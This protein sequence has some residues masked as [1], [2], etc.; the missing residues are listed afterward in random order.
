MRESLAERE[1]LL[2]IAPHIISPMRFVLVHVDGLRPRWVIRIG[3]A[4]YDRLARRDILPPTNTLDLRDD[5]AGKPLKEQFGKAFEY[6]DCWVD[7]SRLVTL[8]ALDAKEHGATIL[9]KTKLAAANQADGCWELSLD[10]DHARTAEAT[11]LVNA[12]GPWAGKLRADILDHAPDPS[13]TTRL[14]Q[15]SH[16]VLPRLFDHDKGYI[17]Q[18]NDQRI[19]FALPYKDKHT[20]V[21][22]TDREFE[23][24]PYGASISEEETIYL[25]D[26]VNRFFEKKSSR[27]DVAW[28]F[29]G[30]RGLYDD[31]AKDAQEVTRDYMIKIDPKPIPLV[32]VFGGKLTTYRRLSEAVVDQCRPWLGNLPDSNTG[33][34]PLPGGDIPV[35]GIEKLSER[36][37]QDCDG[38]GTATARR[39]AKAYGSRADS[40]TNG[41]KDVSELGEEFGHGLFEAEL[42]YLMEHEWAKTADDVLYRRTK[43]HLAL[44][45]KQ[46]DKVA[47]WM[48][49]RA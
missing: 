30:V 40:V 12:S 18:G 26:A 5:V 15:G 25:L 49:D 41:A 19:V 14:V 36:L 1:R 27:D 7:D 22:T 9:S 47:R 29:S 32:N 3:L 21:G 44:D 4:I 43:L 8:N 17:L 2:R 23:G 28:S 10:G 11:V 31:G 33:I 39:L 16:I 46:Q 20:L 48:E 35:D 34:N 24:D 42:E 37:A 13:S 38:I 6:S 45:D